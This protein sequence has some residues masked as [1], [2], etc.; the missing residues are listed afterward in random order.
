[1]NYWSY[2]EPTFDGGNNTIT[3]SEDEIIARYWKFWY[4]A[5]CKKHGKE[6]VD[7]NYCEKDCIDDWVVIHWA[8]KSE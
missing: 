8:R 3:L 2:D 7:E 4:P 6:H 5:M 1:M